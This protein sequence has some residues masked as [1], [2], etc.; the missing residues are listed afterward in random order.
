[1]DNGTQIALTL[2]ANSASQRVKSYV[3]RGRL[4]QNLSDEELSAMMVWAFREFEKASFKPHSK[5]R[6]VID[7]IGAE[8]DLRGQERP[9]HLVKDQVD[10]MI[11]T[12]AAALDETNAEMLE[13]LNAEMVEDY[14]AIKR[15]E[16]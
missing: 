9:Y 6:L 11:A 14:E 4:M 2:M 12:A 16:H 1:M 15:S 13:R 5:E 7:D 8:Y 3:D 10:K